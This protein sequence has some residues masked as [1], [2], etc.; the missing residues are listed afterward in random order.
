MPPALPEDFPDKALVP[1]A[2]QAVTSCLENAWT[3]GW[4][5]KTVEIPAAW[6]GKK[7]LLHFEAVGGSSTVYFN[8]RELGKNTQMA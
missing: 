6:Q 2:T 4:Y 5:R 3:R 8:S 1:S 7:V